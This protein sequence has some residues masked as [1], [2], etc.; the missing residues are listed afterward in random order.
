YLRKRYHAAAEKL[1]VED[2]KP[3]DAEFCRALA[4]AIEDM[5]VSGDPTLHVE[6]RETQ[7]MGET[8]QALAALSRGSEVLDS[9]LVFSASYASERQK[10]IV[11][12]LGQTLEQ[13]ADKELVQLKPLEAGDSR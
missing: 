2:D 6:I 7:D 3:R 11:E 8:P 13:I 5:A 4:A 1:L 10:M 9:S 12:L